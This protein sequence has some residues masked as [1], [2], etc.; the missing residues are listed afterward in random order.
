MHSANVINIDTVNGA[1]LS[2]N[3][4]VEFVKVSLHSSYPLDTR[5][6][7]KLRETKNHA[8]QR[9]WKVHTTPYAKTLLIG[10]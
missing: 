7:A 10:N 9:K 4:T 2:T 6:L 1:T 8:W 3:T 5:D